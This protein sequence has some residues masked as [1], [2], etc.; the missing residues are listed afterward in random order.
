MQHAL[1]ALMLKEVFENS[2]NKDYRGSVTVSDSGYIFPKYTSG[3]QI[4]MKD[5]S[6]REQVKGLLGWMNKILKNG[7]FNLVVKDRD[8]KCEYCDYSSACRR[9]KVAGS[10]KSKETAFFEWNE[11]KAEY[12]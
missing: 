5:A 9:T 11:L 1:Y 4:V 8:K 10:L 7:K 3:R 6:K 12:E 2:A